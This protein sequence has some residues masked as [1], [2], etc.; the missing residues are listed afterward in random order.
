MQGGQVGWGNEIALRQRPPRRQVPLF[1]ARMTRWNTDD[2][3]KPATVAGSLAAHVRITAVCQHCHRDSL[4]D[5]DALIAAGHGLKPLISRRYGA[6]DAVGEGTA[7]SSV[8]R[9]SGHR[10]A[11]GRLIRAPPSEHEVG[12]LARAEFANVGRASGR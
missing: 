2:A 6:E 3:I 4:L 9:I 5:L 12:I 11:D 7:S 8:A 1:F 10:S